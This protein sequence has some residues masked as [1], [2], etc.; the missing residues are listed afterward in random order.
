MNGLSADPVIV[1]VLSE[2]DAAQYV[3]VSSEVIFSIQF[4]V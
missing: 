1:H 2:E 3:D 4:Y